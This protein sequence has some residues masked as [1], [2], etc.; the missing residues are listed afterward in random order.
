MTFRKIAFSLTTFSKTN[1]SNLMNICIYLYV[2]VR[3]CVCLCILYICKVMFIC[4]FIHYIQGY[5]KLGCICTI[6]Y[7]ECHLCS[8]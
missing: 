1:A 2:C 8:V 3:V 4:K 6:L 5:S 7:A